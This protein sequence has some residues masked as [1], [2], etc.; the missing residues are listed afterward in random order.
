M[1]PQLRPPRGRRPVKP[2]RDLEHDLEHTIP[3]EG[4]ADSRRLF[5]DMTARSLTLLEVK[6]G[7]RVLDLA[8]GMGQDTLAIAAES[9]GSGGP[10]PDAGPALTIGAEPSNRMIRWGQG[11][12]RAPSGPADAGE[13]GRPAA[14]VRAYAEAL[15]FGDG[16]LDA[17]LCK[18]AMD[19]FVSPGRTMAEIARVLRP[20]GRA[21]LAIANYDSLSCRLGRLREGWLR[22]TWPG[23]VT[24]A[25]PYFEPPPDH[26]TRFGYRQ[27]LALA[28]PPLRLR[29][30][31][32]VSL[33]WGFPPWG[34]LLGGMPKP[35]TALLL[36]G[37]AALGRVFP[38]WADVIVVRVEKPSPGG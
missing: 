18:G 27:I 36:G 9:A 8:C 16:V 25:H 22:R 6:A 2:P 23:H 32:G 11:Q 7:E 13:A 29:R 21:V 4:G 5:G 35:L 14:W 38:A 24:P 33:L 17:V 30:V 19:H 26:L 31:E 12:A 20:G 3:P 10:D 28:G 15:P 37:A 34:N 1:V